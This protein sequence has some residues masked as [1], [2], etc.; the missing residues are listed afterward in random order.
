MEEGASQNI[1]C[2]LTGVT[3]HKYDKFFN[4]SG[5]KV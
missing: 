2:W 5:K 4:Y 1:C 3:S